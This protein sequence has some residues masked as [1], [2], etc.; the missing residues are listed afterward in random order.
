[1]DR[2]TRLLLFA[3][4]FSFLVRAQVPAS[5]RP[6]SVGDENGGKRLEWLRRPYQSKSV[7]SVDET[8]TPRIRSLIRAGNLYL[9][10]ADALALAIENN[11][12]VQAARYSIPISNTDLL[13][14]KGGGTLRG[15]GLGTFEVPAGVGGP[16]SPLINAAAA[17]RLRAHRC[18]PTFTI[19]PCFR[20]RRRRCPWTPGP[21]FRRFP[22]RPGRQFRNSIR[23]LSGAWDGRARRRQSKTLCRAAQACFIKAA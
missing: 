10:L 8:N 13:R 5:D 4:L 21:W 23:P 2:D 3:A 14:A 19:S 12:D 18:L 22:R 6:P 20:R 15:V 11:L 17:D 1:M 7:N 16:A 9:S